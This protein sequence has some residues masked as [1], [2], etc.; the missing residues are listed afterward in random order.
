MVSDAHSDARATYL[1]PEFSFEAVY[2]S[3][4]NI[5]DFSDKGKRGHFI[6]KQGN[7]ITQSQVE[8]SIRVPKSKRKF[9]M[10]KEEM[11]YLFK[12]IK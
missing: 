2:D 7:E 3:S 4:R 9:K 12:K 5:L 6:T 8:E 1:M 11:F 10:Q